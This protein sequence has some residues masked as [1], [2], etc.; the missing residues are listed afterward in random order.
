MHSIVAKRLLALVIDWLLICG[1]LIVL[2]IVAFLLYLIVWDRIPEFSAI[3]TQ[4]IA[5]LTTVVPVTIWFTLK[6]A[7][8]PFA[9]TGKIQTELTVNYRGDAVKS[10][11]IRNVLKFLPWQL[12][13]IGVIHGYYTDFETTT[14][15]L[16]VLG[17]LFLAL[18][19][20][21]Q[22]AITPSHRHFPDIV[23]GAR[24]QRL[25]A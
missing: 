6:E 2:T 22:V 11:L 21:M 24:V 13:H 4:V 1:Y 14:S 16:I 17:S 23:A 12:A 8:I 9:T 7:Q 19:Y 20:V 25:P 3:Q 10:A 5:A 18:T 15:M